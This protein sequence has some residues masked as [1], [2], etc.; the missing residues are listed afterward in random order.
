M[1][2]YEI[3]TGLPNKPGT[4]VEL[5][6]PPQAQDGEILEL[7]LEDGRV[8]LCQVRGLSPYCRLIGERPAHERRRTRSAAA[9]SE[10][11]T[12]RDESGRR[13]SDVRGA[14]AISHPCPR[15]LATETLIT[16]RGV[17][18]TTLF[19]PVCRHGWG[20]SP[21]VVAAAMHLDR[22]AIPRAASS[23][24]R[25]DDRLR[26]PTCAYCATDVHVRA[27][28]RTPDEIFFSCAGCDAMW[29][30]PHAR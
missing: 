18:L 19:C 30:L 29:A 13:K 28:R 20:E 17:T 21:A 1:T 8:L 22:R 10:A 24:R 2:H 26:V 23:E 15:C 16:H 6:S 3:H 14:A 12:E 27:I 7:A 4:V 9:A 5:E 11:A 25:G